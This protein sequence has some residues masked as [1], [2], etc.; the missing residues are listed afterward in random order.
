MEALAKLLGWKLSLHGVPTQ[1][2]V[3]LISGGGE[4]NRYPNG[5]PVLFERISGHRDSNETT[6]PGDALY[7]QLPDLRARAARY[8][9]PVSAHHGRARPASTASRRSPS[10]ASCASP[11][12]PPPRGAPLAVEYTTRGRGLDAGHD[13]HR[14]PRRRL[15]RERRAARQRAGP[16]GVR[17]ATAR[18]AGSSRSRSTSASSRA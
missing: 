5:T 4:T 14:G 8:A 11:T 16:R 15:G 6:C 17:A 13:D 7:A 1:G 2:T 10:R 18:A 12:A 3:T 9:V